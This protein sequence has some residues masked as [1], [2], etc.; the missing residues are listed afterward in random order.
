MLAGKRVARKVTPRF[1]AAYDIAVVGL[2]TAGAESLIE[3]ESSQARIIGIERS[4]GMGG[5]G[6][7]GGV[8][9]WSSIP[10][11]L[12]DY[13]RRCQ[14][15]EISYES[16]VIGIWT[17]GCRISGVRFCRHGVVN[18]VS[19]RCLIDASGNATVARLLGLPL[20][21]GRPFDSAMASLSR[22]ESWQ[23]GNGVVN[24][25]YSNY[26]L[27]PTGSA[28][29]YSDIV[30]F[31]A[32]ERHLNW[33]N[34][35]RGGRML[36]PALMVAAREECRVTTEEILTM[37]DELTNKKFANPIFYAFGPEDLPIGGIAYESEEIQ[38]WKVLCG[39]A[40]FG[41]PTT[42]TYGTIVAKGIDNLFVPSK[43]FG[44]AHDLGGTLRMQ[45]EM[46]KTGAVAAWA[47]LIALRL[48][49]AARDVP[50]SE[51][52]PV[53]EHAG[54]LKPPAKVRMNSVKGVQFT[55]FSAEDVVK[56][57]RCDVVCTGEWW[58]AEAK[59]GPDERAAY[60]YWT[61]W[62][63]GLCGGSSERQRMGDALAA[64]A[65]RMDRFTGNCAVAL[66]LLGDLRAIP[67]LRAIV[68]DLGGPNS[69]LIPNSVPNFTK[70][71]ILLGRFTDEKCLQ[72]LVMI[73]EDG[74]RSV[75]AA[76]IKS[77]A[78]SG[79]PED[80]RCLQL[81][82]LLIA[83]REILHAHPNDEIVDRICAWQR[84]EPASLDMRGRDRMSNLRKISVR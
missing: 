21:T 56:S 67:Y 35:Q 37:R 31:L 63:C 9:Y 16:V 32:R 6:T 62:Q 65:S 60:A 53:L 7:V 22:A 82:Y 59:G 54:Y 83:L 23:D 1:G 70:A 52:R 58:R 68:T 61:A 49:C 29:A 33:K 30:S 41:Y 4:T 19:V 14:R 76:F 20:R 5:L 12:R 57:L 24:P 10:D 46:K 11:K 71:V 43:H 3:L 55:P 78:V 80:I 84:Q 51:L 36:A 26:L 42:V 73:V 81:S 75:T 28:E 72:S 48:G 74:A 39:L 15:V 44:V 34:L 13:E 18:D 45:G 64:S 38:N 40:L 50:Y 2:G 8:S 25:R 17:D 77:G 47:A 69:P 27:D 79:N 66:G